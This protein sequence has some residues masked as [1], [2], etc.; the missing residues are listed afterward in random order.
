MSSDYFKIISKL[1]KDM[2]HSS[3]DAIILSLFVGD[4]DDNLQ[5]INTLTDTLFTLLLLF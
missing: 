5:H 1:R 4:F 3:I 2:L